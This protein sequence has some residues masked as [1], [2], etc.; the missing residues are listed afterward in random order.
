M[1]G[2]RHG[3]NAAVFTVFFIFVLFLSL[4]SSCDRSR[5]EP[6]NAGIEQTH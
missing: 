4:M 2:P 5:A 1:P 6:V 3:K